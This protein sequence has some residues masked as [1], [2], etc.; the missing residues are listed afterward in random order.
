M[1]RPHSELASLLESGVRDGVFP[2]AVAAVVEPD[3]DPWIHAVGHRMIVP[4]RR[5]MSTETVFDLASLTK[6][7][8]T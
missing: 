6:P 2:G 7:L 4:T 1:S 3:A 5:E 8:V